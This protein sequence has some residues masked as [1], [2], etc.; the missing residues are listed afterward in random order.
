MQ[1]YVESLLT[2]LLVH[3]ESFARLESLK[4]ESKSIFYGFFKTRHTVAQMIDEM[5]PR[6]LE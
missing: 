1:S 4:T 5:L 6:T 3:S 2:L